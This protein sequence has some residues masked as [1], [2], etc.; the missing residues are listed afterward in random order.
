[1][2]I[3]DTINQPQQGAG[4][5]RPLVTLPDMEF[6]APVVAGKRHRDGIVY[7]IEILTQWGKDHKTKL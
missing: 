3:N 1:M 7:R 5:I 6:A 2:T 4:H